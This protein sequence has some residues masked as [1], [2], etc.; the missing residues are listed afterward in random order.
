[1][2]YLL[3][4]TRENGFCWPSVE[5]CES[6]THLAWVIK[7]QLGIRATTDRQQSYVAL[8]ENSSEEETNITT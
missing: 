4:E 2:K 1:M 7:K 6:R 3:I 8:S 5:D